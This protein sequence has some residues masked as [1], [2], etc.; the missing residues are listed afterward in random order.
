MSPE[1]SATLDYAS[2][3]DRSPAFLHQLMEEGEH[4]ADTF[5]SGV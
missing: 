3:L 1:L 4:R 2:K 5:L